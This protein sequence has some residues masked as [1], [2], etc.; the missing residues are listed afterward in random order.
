[1]PS[2][3]AIG[4]RISERSWFDYIGYSELPKVIKPWRI[5]LLNTRAL[6]IGIDLGAN[7][8]TIIE[9][10]HMCVCVCVWKLRSLL[11]VHGI[12]IRQSDQSRV[13][14]GLLLKKRS[15]ALIYEWNEQVK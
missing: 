4:S 2:I 1:M 5:G 13:E 8:H 12:S 9:C 10:A 6:A 11:P 3:K 14:F 15:L 7:V